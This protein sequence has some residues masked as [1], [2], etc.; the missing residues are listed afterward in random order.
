MQN[1]IGLINHT[2]LD[3]RIDVGSV[4]DV[5]HRVRVENDEI[6][7]IALFELADLC[8]GIPAKEFRCIRRGASE[9]LHD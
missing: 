9:N 7:K 2:I 4:R 8:A 6:G 1:G 3:H 5:I